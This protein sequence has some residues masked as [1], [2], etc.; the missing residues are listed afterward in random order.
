MNGSEP[1][2]L[3]KSLAGCLLA[4]QVPDSIQ[5]IITVT[6][7]YECTCTQKITYACTS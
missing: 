6:L 1:F 4:S 5:F 2:G 7:P 3:H